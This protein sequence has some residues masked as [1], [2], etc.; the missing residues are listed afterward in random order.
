MVQVRR[1]VPLSHLRLTCCA[2]DL[3]KTVLQPPPLMPLPMSALSSKSWSS[4]NSSSSWMSPR[5][6]P[7][8]AE[9]VTSQPTLTKEIPA[10]SRIPPRL[11]T[12]L[13]STRTNRSRPQI[14][15]PASLRAPPLS[16]VSHP[17]PAMTFCTGGQGSVTSSAGCPPRM[18][19]LVLCKRF[20]RDLSGETATSPASSLIVN[21]KRAPA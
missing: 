8:T 12:R 7:S 9:V 17:H 20:N 2:T 14:F 16:A 5:P 13:K 3:A 19:I 21:P 6:M 18:S 1:L 4:S 15:N 10:Q 11:P